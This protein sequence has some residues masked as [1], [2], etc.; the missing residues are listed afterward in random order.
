MKKNYEER[1]KE[2]TIF[3]V[4][5]FFSLF[6]FINRNF[7]FTEESLPLKEKRK[8][9]GCLDF[10]DEKCPLSVNKPEFLFLSI[11]CTQFLSKHKNFLFIFLKKRVFFTWQRILLRPLE[12]FENNLT[13]IIEEEEKFFGINLNRSLENAMI[14]LFYQK[15]EK[16]K[17]ELERSSHLGSVSLKVTGV[18]RRKTEWQEEDIPQ[19]S[20]L[21][22]KVQTAPNTRAVIFCG[23]V[24]YLKNFFPLDLFTEEYCSVFIEKVLILSQ[25]KLLSQMALEMELELNTKD[26]K[27]KRK[28]VF[29]LKTLLENTKQLLEFDYFFF[30]LLSTK[31]EIYLKM[32][33]TF[34]ELKE[35]RKA[36]ELFLQ[37]KNFKQA[38]TCFFL[39]GDKKKALSLTKDDLK[40]NKEDPE[41]WCILGDLSGDKECYQKA[42]LFSKGRSERALKT[43][44]VCFYHQKDYKKANEC[45][46]KALVLNPLN[47]ELL[48]IFGCSLV[49]E[50]EFKKA[51][52][53]FIRCLSLNEDNPETWNNIAAIH[54]ETKNDKEALC[55]LKKAVYYSYDN[56]KLWENILVLSMSS[57]DYFN[58]LSSF[59]RILEIKKE[60][61][62]SW[63]FIKILGTL[64]EKELELVGNRE[65]LECVERIVSFLITQEIEL[66]HNP[67][68]L[69]FSISSYLY[70]ANSKI[71]ETALLKTFK[72]IKKIPVSK[73]TIN[74]Y[75]GCGLLMVES[76]EKKYSNSIIEKCLEIESLCSNYK[77]EFFL[78]FEKKLKNLKKIE[79]NKK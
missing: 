14:Y 70:S 9:H 10:Y 77:N 2:T 65:I 78:S 55:V 62:E 41:L 50:K 24:F 48:F 63:L 5:G 34:K 68:S 32:A 54:I 59:E 56:W 8:L 74:D 35:Y 17:E 21:E 76:I 69:W 40:E 58:G 11:L 66:K 46:S 7:I 79:D 4:I 31:K 75:L 29:Q 25:S 30:L 64:Q 73:D 20:L 44:G 60:K 28:T 6:C 47:E 43:L 15:E 45:F 71:I 61:T 37:W 22:E 49:K 53:V 13:A 18:L 42:I 1:I 38:A 27:K 19:L 3:Y 12:I 39:S 67:F 36:A 23:F 57:G 26:E 52:N 16:A 72:E 33:E 51:M